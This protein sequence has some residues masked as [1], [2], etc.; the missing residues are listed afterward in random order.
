M[1]ATTLF[2]RRLWTAGVR[3]TALAVVLCFG[4][5]V[6]SAFAQG[7]LIGRVTN[8][9]TGKPLEGARVELKETGRVTDVDSTGEYR[10]TDVAPG[11]VTVS[12]SY[13]GL[14]TVDDTVSVKSGAPTRHDVG[15]TADIY[16]LS[17][18]VVSGEREGNAMAIQLQR[19]SDGVQNIVSTDAFGSL[20]GNPADLIMRLPGVEAESVGGDRRYV[21]IRGMHQSLSTVTMDG[22][23][24]SSGSGASGGGREFTFNPVGSD[25]IERI[26]VV[27]SPTPDM[28]A[29]SIGGAMNFVSKNA[30]NHGLGR[31]ISGSIG[32]IWRATDP[33]DEPHRNYSVSY[34]EVF[35][36]KIGVAFNYAQRKHGTIIDVAN[37]SW[38][39]V[40]NGSTGPRYNTGFNT[41]DFRNYRTGW[42]G[43]L[44]LDYKL[45]ATSRFYI[46]N[47]MNKYRE[48][49]N[50][51]A[52]RPADRNGGHSTGLHQRHDGV[53][54]GGLC[55]CGGKSRRPEHVDG[56][57][58]HRVPAR[59]VLQH[60]NR[61]HPPLCRARN[62]LD[63]Q[64][65]QVEGAL[66]GQQD[67]QRL[68]AGFWTEDRKK[69]RTVL[70]RHHADLRRE[71]HGYQ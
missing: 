59:P 62:R 41:E 66:P 32:A 40:V 26:E 12:V 17:K 27:K 18:F 47:T 33:R 15:L 5:A 8:A 20:A 36:E 9:A 43:G 30:F 71:F 6:Q 28:S 60:P 1:N 3:T 13:T 54:S 22:S 52:F 48:Y 49:A 46:N 57:L 21:R 51:R 35:G 37:Q 24:V 14:N 38:G 34:S 53:V 63:P 11:A 31:R 68:H 19:K 2:A 65:D 61:R 44:R 64:P 25:T 29:D 16:R 58:P 67:L 55:Q 7:S 45:S 23:A 4:F 69:G 56:H 39:N 70:S 10:F 50:H 42:G